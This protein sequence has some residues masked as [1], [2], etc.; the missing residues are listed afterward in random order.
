MNFSVAENEL[1]LAAENRHP[2]N[3]VAECHSAWAHMGGP[4]KIGVL[5]LHF[6]GIGIV[7]DLIGTRSSPHVLL[8]R[9]WP[10]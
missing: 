7:H 4:K 6:L 1:F 9:I 3:L 5:E 8:Y 2:D 10:V